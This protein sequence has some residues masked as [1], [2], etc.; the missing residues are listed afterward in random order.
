MILEDA[1]IKSLKKYVSRAKQAALFQNFPT[2]KRR[3]CGALCYTTDTRPQ[4]SLWNWD[5][6]KRPRYHNPRSNLG[7]GIQIQNTDITSRIFLN[8]IMILMSNGNKIVAIIDLNKKLLFSWKNVLISWFEISLVNQELDRN[9]DITI[10]DVYQESDSDIRLW[11]HYVFPFGSFA[12][13]DITLLG[14]I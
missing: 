7:I 12:T 2:F 11:Y 10:E 4:I 14:L 5:L 13:L 9:F 6:N 1:P 3:F 8:N